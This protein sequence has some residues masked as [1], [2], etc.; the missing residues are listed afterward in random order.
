NDLSSNIDR[1][2][3]VAKDWKIGTAE[4]R[5]AAANLQRAMDAAQKH[6]NA[7]SAQFE[8]HVSGELGTNPLEWFSAGGQSKG[9]YSN[10]RQNELNEKLAA[11][12]AFAEKTKKDASESD[13]YG[14]K[15]STSDSSAA[16]A[17][18]QDSLSTAYQ[19]QQ[20]INAS[21]KRS[22]AYANEWAYV[23]TYQ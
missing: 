12:I 13:G 20:A 17:S 9:Q 4:E 18:L 22:E 19:E 10:Q 16:R 6:Q 15:L 23:E 8:A 2:A 11:A 5:E 1:A 3:A 14:T 21:T 7:K